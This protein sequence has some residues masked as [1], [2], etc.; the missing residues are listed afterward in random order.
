MKRILSA[1][2]R[3]YKLY[4]FLIFLLKLLP[5]KSYGQE[6][7]L[8]EPKI[9]YHL[10]FQEGYDEALNFIKENG[11]ISDSLKIHGI[12]PDFAFSIVFPEL[13]RYSS[14]Q[15]KMEVAGLLTL[16]VQYGEKY[17]DFSVGHF[18]MKPTFVEQL[19]KD[20][21]KYVLAGCDSFDLAENANA[22]LERVKRLNDIQWQLKY[23]CLYIQ[24][25]GMRYGTI[26]WNNREERVAFYATAYNSGYF[27]GE[28]K[29]RCRINSKMFYT[30]LVKGNNC[31]SYSAISVHFF[32][33]INTNGMDFLNKN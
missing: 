5:V 17:A 2:R 1:I 12:D 31:Y 4:F 25:I 29:I 18:Q 28:E 19:E 11:W 27:L 22:R 30:G 7:F 15:D 10:I 20:A 14:I 3:N 21:K 13:I 24:V 32:N 6:L 23:L 8:S 16:Y 26:F 33:E 9:D